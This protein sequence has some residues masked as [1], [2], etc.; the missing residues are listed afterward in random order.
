MLNGAVL[1]NG[2]LTTL[3]VAQLS[4]LSFVAGS[5]STPV[6]DTLEV[7]A[8]DASGFGPFTT[9][10]VMAS[11]HAST[12][13]PTVTAANELEAPSLTLAASSLFSATASGGNTIAAYEVVDTTTDSGHWVFNGT[14]EPSNQH[15]VVTTAQLSELSFDTGYGS[16][17]LMVRANDGS[18]WGSFVGFTVTPPPNAPPPAGT[19]DTLVM[20]RN[21]DGAM[22][23]MTSARIPSCSTARSARSPRRC[24][25]RASAALTAATPPIC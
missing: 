2:Q 25:S 21:G 17:T 19:E 12:S 22:S 1:P 20:L 9:V 15:I 7:A 23:S 13:P 16:D 24:R 4:Q 14:V 18:Q 11:A 10:M 3:T 5:A 6:S 8:S